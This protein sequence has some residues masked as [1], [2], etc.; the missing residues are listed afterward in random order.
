[1]A[2]PVYADLVRPA[3]PAVARVFDGALVAGFSLVIALGAQIAIPLPFTPVP[4]T[5]QTLAVLL[6]GCTLGKGRGALAVIVYIVE[7]CAGL[8]VFSGGTG[9]IVH[10]LGPTGGYL[11][12]FVAA[13]YLVGLLAETGLTVKWLGSVLT[14]LAGNAYFHRIFSLY[15]IWRIFADGQVNIL[16]KAFNQLICFR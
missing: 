16:G 6:A 4:V 12:G 2:S 11:V 8:P 9:G 7:G 15:K 3:R 14:L 5:L 10:L 13:A 1:M